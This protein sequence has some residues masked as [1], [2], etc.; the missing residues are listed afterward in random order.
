M[1]SELMK[2]WK[3]QVLIKESDKEIQ[4]HLGISVDSYVRD[5]WISILFDMKVSTLFNMSSVAKKETLS[6]TLCIFVKTCFHPW[7]R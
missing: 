5:K 6:N 1:V 3:R 2:Q 4:R 7:L